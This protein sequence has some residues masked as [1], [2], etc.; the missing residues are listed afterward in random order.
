MQSLKQI[1]LEP[2]LISQRWLIYEEDEWE[3]F[4]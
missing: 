4:A 3:V 2:L 1:H